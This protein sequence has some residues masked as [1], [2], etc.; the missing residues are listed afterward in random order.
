VVCLVFHFI[1]LNIK[2]TYI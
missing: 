2:R 1:G